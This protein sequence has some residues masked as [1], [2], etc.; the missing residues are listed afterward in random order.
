[1]NGSGQY[2]YEDVNLF[3]LLN[4]KLITFK[5]IYMSEELYYIDIFSQSIKEKF[6]RNNEI[7]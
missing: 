4:N 1:M 7:N 3:F 5:Y 6:Y 2:I